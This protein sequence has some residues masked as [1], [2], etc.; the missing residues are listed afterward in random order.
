MKKQ[1]AL[2]ATLLCLFS[3]TKAFSQCIISGG[4]LKAPLEFQT[5][6]EVKKNQKKLIKAAKKGDLTLK[7]PVGSSFRTEKGLETLF[8][9]CGIKDSSHLFRVFLGRGN[10]IMEFEHRLKY[11]ESKDFYFYIRN[12]SD[13]LYINSYGGLMTEKEFNEYEKKRISKLREE[14]AEKEKNGKTGYGLTTNEIRDATI[15]KIN[16]LK[17]EY[18]EKLKNLYETV[19]KEFLEENSKLEKIASDYESKK[20]WAYALF[21]YYKLFKTYS[22]K[23][24]SEKDTIAEYNNKVRNIIEEAQIPYKQNG[25]VYYYA[26]NLETYNYKDKSSGYTKIKLSAASLDNSS[27]YKELISAISSGKPWIGDYDDFSLYDGWKDLLLNL[28]KFFSVHPPFCISLGKLSK[29]SADMKTRTY[30]YGVSINTEHTEFYHDL[31]GSSYSPVIKEGLKKAMKSSWTD[32]PEKWPDVSILN[33]KGDSTKLFGKVY[34]PRKTTLIKGVPIVEFYGDFEEKVKNVRNTLKTTRNFADAY[35]SSL[36]GVSQMGYNMGANM[37]MQEY[38]DA[39][40]KDINTMRRLGATKVSLPLEAACFL[41][42]F[43]YD[44]KLNIVDENGKILVKGGRKL[45]IKEND[46]SSVDYNFE[47]ISP[48]IA[49]LIDEGKAK[50]VVDSLYLNYGAIDENTVSTTSRAFV[51]NLPDIQIDLKNVEIR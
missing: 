40:N 26:N 10:L 18:E 22:E 1:I 24:A 15:A 12:N 20:E 16:I 50:A 21:Y 27:K 35:G 8:S 51:K 46:N 3:A 43:L 29:G 36:Y 6:E 44:I 9:A 31:I 37:A 19:A 38:E 28:E 39:L 32:I 34:K 2:I 41:G 23:T 30:T 45:L 7:V 25:Q 4:N 5:I 13:S 14:E 48:E 42:T 11:S 17:I 49:K 47:G 33:D